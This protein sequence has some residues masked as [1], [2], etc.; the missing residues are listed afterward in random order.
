MAFRNSMQQVASL[1]PPPPM[2]RHGNEEREAPRW[3]W[4]Q[5]PALF[6]ATT[7]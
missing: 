5:Q 7:G 1:I 2:K 4:L 3:T 6:M